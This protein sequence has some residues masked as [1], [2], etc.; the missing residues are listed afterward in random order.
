MENMDFVTK[1]LPV[2]VLK[3]LKIERDIFC[4][5]RRWVIHTVLQI[6]Q[7]PNKSICLVTWWE[8]YPKSTQPL[9]WHRRLLKAAC[10]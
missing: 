6:E 9:T 2:M 10:Y 4:K 7:W 1:D 8:S 5:R 3:S